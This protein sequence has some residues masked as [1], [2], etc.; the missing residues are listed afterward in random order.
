MNND[1]LIQRFSPQKGARYT[2]TQR[3]KVS[4][5]K[6]VPEIPTLKPSGVATRQGRPGGFRCILIQSGERGE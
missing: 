3:E 1:M 2:G 6:G 5:P 4:G